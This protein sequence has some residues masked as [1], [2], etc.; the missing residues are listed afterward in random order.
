MSGRGAR[1][2]ARRLFPSPQLTAMLNRTYVKFGKKNKILTVVKELYLRKDIFCGS[3]LCSECYSS[4]TLRASLADGHTLSQRLSSAPKGS[5]KPVDYLVIDTNIV[6]HQMD[7]LNKPNFRNIVVLQTV[8]N[9]V[10][11]QSQQ[12]HAD[13]RELCSDP[14]KQFYVFSNEFRE[15]V[16]KE[17][18]PEFRFNLS[19]QFLRSSS[20]W[21]LNVILCSFCCFLLTN[22]MRY[23]GQGDTHQPKQGRD[24]K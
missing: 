24:S 14:E 20:Y 5:S 2:S 16:T 22:S 7:I 11:N 21:P 17:S 13:L 4:K 9:E 8:L 15:Y 6:L 12:L 18:N 23:S 3:E 1:G 19:L 10:K